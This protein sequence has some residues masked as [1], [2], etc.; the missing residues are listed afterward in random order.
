MRERIEQRVRELKAEQQRGQ[1]VL[2]EL[3]AQQANL[4][5]TL[6]RIS[7]AIQALEGCAT[8]QPWRRR[9]R[10][11]TPRASSDSAAPS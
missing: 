10:C 11:G 2:A 3:E 5:Q 9:G 7:G 8:V 1:Q 4:H 6:L